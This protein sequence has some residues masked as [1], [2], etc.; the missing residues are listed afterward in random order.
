MSGVFLFPTSENIPTFAQ[1]LYGET[2]IFPALIYLITIVYNAT[3][4][5]FFAF[6]KFPQPGKRH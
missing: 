6:R 1:K 4:C 3:D 5:P 2:F